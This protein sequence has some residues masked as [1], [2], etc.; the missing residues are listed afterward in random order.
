MA[1][2]IKHV[3]R[4]DWTPCSKS[5]TWEELIQ[6]SIKRV[7]TQPNF[8]VVFCLFEAFSSNQTKTSPDS[9]IIQE[10]WKN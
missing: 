7:I 2:V 10:N 6:R 3:R 9:A 1:A 8:K 4:I 5:R